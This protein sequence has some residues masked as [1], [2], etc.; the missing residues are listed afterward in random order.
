MDVSVQ[1]QLPAQRGYLLRFARQRIADAAIAEDLVQETLLSALQSADGFA[2]RASLRTW[3]TSILLH[4]IADHQRREYRSPLVTLLDEE[5]GSDD[6]APV[7]EAGRPRAVDH[8][9]PQRLLEGR[10]L[11]ERLRQ[12]MAAL[13]P[14]AARVFTLRELD[15]LDNQQVAQQ[16]GIAAERCAVL[17]HRARARLRDLLAPRTAAA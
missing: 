13:P 15:G 7:D 4:R 8:H 9:D 12:A 14:L 2:G 10:Q 6:D 5:S 3:L 16:L 17:L 1:R 11:V